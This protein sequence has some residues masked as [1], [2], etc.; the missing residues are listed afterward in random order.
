MEARLDI[1]APWRHSAEHILDKGRHVILVL[2]ASDRGKSSYCHYLTQWLVTAGVRVAFVD[3]DIGQKDVGPP[4]TITLAYP[5]AGQSLARAALAGLYFVGAVTPVGHFLAMVVGTRRLLD[6]ADAP[7][8]IVDTTGLVLRSGRIL[9]AC[10]IESLRP[11]LIVCLEKG[12]ELESLLKPHRHLDILRLAPSKQAVPKSA[13]QRKEARQRAFRRYFAGA[14]ER[15][16]ELGNVVIQRA[17]LFYGRH[18]DDPHYLYAEQVDEGIVAIA[19]HNKASPPSGVKLLPLGFERSL[20]CGIADSHGDGL[21]LAILKQIDF[22]RQRLTLVTP[23]AKRQLRIVQ[24]GHLHLSPD[25]R[26][27]GHPPTATW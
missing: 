6:A 4:A 20:L 16:V 18:L 21:G 11:D 10:Q 5:E 23:L 3:A 27:L 15:V 22:T 12:R 25:G 14:R 17:P 13:R 19:R 9:K 7:F 24:F 2:G 8:V 1:P 26:E